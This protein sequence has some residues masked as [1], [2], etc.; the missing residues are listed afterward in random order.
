MRNLEDLP[1]NHPVRRDA[2][3]PAVQAAYEAE[4]ARTR[5]VDAARAET[6]AIARSAL[7]NVPLWEML[8][9]PAKEQAARNVLAGT[10]T[11]A[12]LLLLRAETAHTGETDVQL[13]T[14][15]VQLADAFRQLAGDLKGRTR[16]AERGL[17]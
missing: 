15:I 7:W 8:S 6:E 12:D 9:W 2:V 16:A 17:T 11:A 1:P 10:A 4:V 5:A 13:A 3:D 14:L